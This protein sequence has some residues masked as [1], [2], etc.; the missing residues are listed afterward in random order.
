MQGACSNP[1]RDMLIHQTYIR[2]ICV[3]V[4]MLY[5]SEHLAHGNNQ[6]SNT[7]PRTH[8]HKQLKDKHTLTITCYS[9]PLDMQTQFSSSVAVPE[10]SRLL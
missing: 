9:L 2:Y 3:E 6:E 4:N 10:C 1:R 8:K 5:V 7:L